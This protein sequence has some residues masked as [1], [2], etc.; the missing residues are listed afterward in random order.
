MSISD[1]VCSGGGGLSRGPL[2]TLGTWSSTSDTQENAKTLAQTLCSS[3]VY[4]AYFDLT[5]A[6]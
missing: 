6:S 1:A 2:L 5:Q 3:E 4:Y